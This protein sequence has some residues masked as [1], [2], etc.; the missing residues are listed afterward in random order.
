MT[1]D[2]S[3]ATDGRK[4]VGD[5]RSEDGFSSAAVAISV[6]IHIAAMSDREDYQ[7]ARVIVYLIDDPIV[8][9]AKAIQVGRA[10]ELDRKSVV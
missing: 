8:S 6:S 2:F 3:D 10:G 5:Q 9:D 1:T 4:E 7:P